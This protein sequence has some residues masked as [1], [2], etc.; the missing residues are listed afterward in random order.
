MLKKLKIG[1]TFISVNGIDNNSVMTANIDE[2]MTQQIVLN[3]SQEK[4][5]VLDHNKFNK[6]DFY[7]FYSLT[8]LT[9]IITDSG[10]NK[11]V[12][13]KYSEYTVVHTPQKDINL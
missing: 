3:N 11:E 1:K 12:E 6:E 13:K 4:Y 10:I 2:G 8:N 7:E 5:I 9:G